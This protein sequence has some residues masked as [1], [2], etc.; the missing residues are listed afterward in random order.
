[1]SIG[2]T[3]KL[4]MSMKC[5]IVTSLSKVFIYQSTT[6]LTSLSSSL[7]NIRDSIDIMWEDLIGKKNRALNLQYVGVK[8]DI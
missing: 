2:L 1:M 4:V 7:M 6:F 5:G 8:A 3:F